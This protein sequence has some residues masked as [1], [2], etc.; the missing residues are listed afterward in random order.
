MHILEEKKK[1]KKR[2]RGYHVPK[3]KRYNSW[4]LRIRRRTFKLKEKRIWRS[5]IIFGGH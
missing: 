2:E 1:K 3:K 4:H 5:K